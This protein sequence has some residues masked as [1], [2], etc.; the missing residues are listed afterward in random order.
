MELI[1]VHLHQ[2]SRPLLFRSL[3][4]LRL[5]FSSWVAIGYPLRRPYPLALEYLP[6]TLHDRLYC[7]RQTRPPQLRVNACAR[8]SIVVSKKDFVGVDAAKESTLT[9]VAFYNRDQRHRC[10][11]VLVLRSTK[12]APS[13]RKPTNNHCLHV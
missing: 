8:P 12:R 11:R 10:A 7:R 6:R 5:S 4:A 3:L 9:G 2:V 1:P 13:L